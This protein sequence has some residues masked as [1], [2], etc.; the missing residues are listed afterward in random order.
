MFDDIKVNIGFFKYQ[1]YNGKIFDYPI[2]EIIDKKHHGII[3]FSKIRIDFIE[4][5]Y[6]RNEINYYLEPIEIKYTDL[7]D[8]KTQLIWRR[9][10]K[11]IENIYLY[12]KAILSWMDKENIDYYSVIDYGPLSLISREKTHILNFEDTKNYVE[13][14]DLNKNAKEF[15]SSHNSKDEINERIKLIKKLLPK[16]KNQITKSIM[17]GIRKFKTQN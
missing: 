13:T 1:K 7:Y 4:F 5:N 6:N 16:N 12:K 11:R 14:S 15:I 3:Y 2:A 8:N 10:K 9:V 17:E